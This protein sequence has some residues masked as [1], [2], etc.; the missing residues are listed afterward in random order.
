MN[1]NGKAPVVIFSIEL[2]A[3]CQRTGFDVLQDLGIPY[4]EIEGGVGCFEGVKEQ[5][6]AI[7]QSRFTDEVKAFLQGNGQR[8]VL[9][10]DNQYNAWLATAEND[11]GNWLTE[12]VMPQYLGTFRQLPESQ[13]VKAQGWSRF[14]G[15]YYVAGR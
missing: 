5:C 11:Y 4:K 3:G 8:C 12:G 10:L 7:P 2:G 15:K 14:G 13:A 1:S 9:H 6:Y